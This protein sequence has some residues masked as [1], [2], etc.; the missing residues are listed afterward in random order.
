MKIEKAQNC[1]PQQ[2]YHGNM[3]VQFASPC[4]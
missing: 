4:C 1:K 2:C 3:T